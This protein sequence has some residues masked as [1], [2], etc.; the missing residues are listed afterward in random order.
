MPELVTTDLS[1]ATTNSALNSVDWMIVQIANMEPYPGSNQRS[2]YNTW[3]AS[4]GGTGYPTRQLWDYTSC[5]PN[6]ASSTTGEYPNY[7]I[8]NLPV[9]N[10]ALEWMTYRNNQVGELYYELDGCMWGNNG[11]TTPWGDQLSDGVYGDGNLLYVG[12]NSTNCSSCGGAF[13]GVS[14][15]IWMPS[16]RIKLYRDGI[17]D[18]EY[19]YLLNAV[20]QT[21]TVT[22]AINE[23]IGTACNFNAV[24]TAPATVNDSSGGCQATPTVFTGDITDAKIALGQAVHQLTFNGNAS[25]S[26]SGAIL[27]GGVIP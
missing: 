24:A 7:A 5:K 10:E 25:G 16:I 21:T 27:S 1:D 23:W 8:D 11:C 3:L 15:P 26:L 4:T 17:Q 12:T 18:Y 19:L 22:N 13:V 2:T 6:C 14:T 20:G 9:A